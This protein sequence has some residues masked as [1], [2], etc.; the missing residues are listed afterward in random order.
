[1]GKPQIFTPRLRYWRTST[2]K[3]QAWLARQLGVPTNYISRYEA[4]TRSMPYEVG[5][6]LAAITGGQIHGGNYRDPVDPKTGRDV[7]VA[8]DGEVTP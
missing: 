4:G 6:K 1:M 5:K 3:T 2:R 7:R 8:T